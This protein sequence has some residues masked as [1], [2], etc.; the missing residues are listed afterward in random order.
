MTD[1]CPFAVIIVVFP[2]WKVAR[3][4]QYFGDPFESG[5]SREGWAEP[6]SLGE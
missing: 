1:A 6:V 2:E 5:P 4:T 3:E